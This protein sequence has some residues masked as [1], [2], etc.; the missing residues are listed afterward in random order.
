MGVA[1]MAIAVTNELCAAV[2]NA[3]GIGCIGMSTDVLNKEKNDVKGG[4]WE[5]STEQLRKNIR[6]IKSKMN[7]DYPLGVDI[8]FGYLPKGADSLICDVLIEEK[9]KFVVAAV[10]VPPKWMVEKL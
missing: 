4:M 3:G 9:V 5:F 8:V 2:C 1:G 6:D 10:G 7:E